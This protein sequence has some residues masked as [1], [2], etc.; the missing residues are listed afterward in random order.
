MANQEHLEILE[1]GV[2]VWNQWRTQHPQIQPELSRTSLGKSLL[3]GANLSG[4]NLTRT[5]LSDVD[6]KDANL[7]EAILSHTNLGGSILNNANLRRASLK[8]AILIGADLSYA[9]LNQ[10]NLNDAY[11]NR[12]NLT[13]TNLSN[14]DL[15]GANFD[16]AKIG[17][18]VFGNNNLSNVG[19]LATVEH[20][21][22]STL[23]IDTLHN[24]Y[25]VSE[26]FL[27]RAGIPEAFITYT[28]ILNARANEFDSCFI[29]YSSKD[30]QFVE[31]LHVDLQAKGV[32]CWFA[33]KD[34]KIGENIRLVLDQSIRKQDKLLLVLSK[35]SVTS[36]WVEKEV[37]TAF[38]REQKQKLTVLFPI[39]L[40]DSVM[41][42]E[43][44]W[45]ADIRRTRHIGDFRKWKN[46]DVYSVALDI[47]INNLKSKGPYR[48]A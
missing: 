25:N 29:S 8:Q 14:A 22:P 39:R 40:D 26:D 38:D 11:L 10:A 9:D 2:D 13:G 3:R 37:S 12:A 17:W 20:L 7:C 24:S 27:R 42:I 43:E 23:G 46:H 33:P 21:G 36:S 28:R 5:N 34:L 15:S 45:P 4:A 32:K 35:S 44:G 41:N 48:R 6:L 1:Q 19:G 18:T 47:L 31:R 30:Q 16:K